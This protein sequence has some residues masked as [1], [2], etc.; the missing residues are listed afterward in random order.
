MVETQEGRPTRK[1]YSKPEV[2]TINLEPSETVLRICKTRSNSSGP[3][4]VWNACYRW[5]WPFL[6]RCNQQ[7]NT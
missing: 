3:G 1:A 4:N 7:S 6:F 2:A 5:F